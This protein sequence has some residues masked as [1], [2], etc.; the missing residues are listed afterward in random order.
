MNINCFK[1]R[2]TNLTDS[3]EQIFPVCSICL[4]IVIFGTRLPCRHLFHK[5]C[6]EKTKTLLGIKKCPNCRVSI[7]PF[8]K[9]IYTLQHDEQKIWNMI[10]NGKITLHSCFEL[11]KK[12]PE[13]F[14]PLLSIITEKYN[15]TNI[16]FEN[17]T[18][19][20]LVRMLVSYKI[21]WHHTVFG[22]SCIELA[23]GECKELLL[24]KCPEEL[25]FFYKKN[26]TN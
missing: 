25:V 26:L 7:F 15:V 16:L 14:K 23:S 2:I 6:F 20:E 5:T 3:I 21:N 12:N 17:I 11:I 18:N 8:E 9:D 24:S 22:K 4:D 19:T 10:Q 13:K 1:K